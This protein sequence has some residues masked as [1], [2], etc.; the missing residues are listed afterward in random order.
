[1]SDLSTSFYA[2]LDGQPEPE[3]DVAEPTVVEALFCIAGAV[4]DLTQAVK[5]QGEQSQ[6]NHD[7]LIR[8]ID[9]AS[10]NPPVFDY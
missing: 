5:E 3:V 1:M 4:D 10:G 8:A 2:H 6:R 9:R 7:S